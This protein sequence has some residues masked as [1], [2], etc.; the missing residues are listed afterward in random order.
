MISIKKLA[1][2]GAAGG[3]LLASAVPAFA[4]FDDDLV[5]GQGNTAIVTNNVGAN[6]NTGLNGVGGGKIV[7][8]WTGGAQSQA[9]VSNVVNKNVAIVH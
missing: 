8:V 3:L 9:T 4:L 6:A 2:V 5:I 7:V 1:T